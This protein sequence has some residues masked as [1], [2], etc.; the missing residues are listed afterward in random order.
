MMLTKPKA[1]DETKESSS[2]KSTT[3]EIAPP[4]PLLPEMQTAGN[5][6]EK[7]LERRLALLG[8]Q[9]EEE[10]AILPVTPVAPAAAQGYGEEKNKNDIQES[11]PFHVEEKPAEGT[12]NLISFEEVTANPVNPIPAAPVEIKKP[13]APAVSKPKKSALLVSE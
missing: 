13:E 8:N 4:P 12:D 1:A 3:L 9:E 5:D 6:L 10:E 11:K 7:E 2:Q